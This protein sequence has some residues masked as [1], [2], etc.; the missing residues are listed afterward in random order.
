MYDSRGVGNGNGNSVVYSG[1]SHGNGN[2]Q[3]EDMLR[4][5]FSNQSLDPNWGR[6]DVDSMSYEQLLERFGAGH[7]ASVRAAPASA[8]ASLPSAPLMEDSTDEAGEANDCTICLEPMAKGA[9][10]SQLPCSH[11]YHTACVS[12]WLRHVNTCPVCKASI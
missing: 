4:L 11:V 2:L 3:F 9:E 7:D 1:G 10:C 6:L 8:I 12:E 5:F